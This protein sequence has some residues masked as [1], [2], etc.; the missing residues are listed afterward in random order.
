[1]KS[2]ETS[3]I[4]TYYVKS[5]YSAIILFSMCIVFSGSPSFAQ[6]PVQKVGM[7]STAVTNLIEKT[8]GDR[9]NLPLK[10]A[11]T[12][13]L[14]NNLDIQIQ[15]VSVSISEKG[16]IEQDARFD[17]VLFGEAS[18]RR[19]EQQTS[20]SLS[21]SPISKLDEQFGRLGIRK[22]F[23]FGLEAETYFETS[24]Y[25]NNSSF[26]GLDP[27]YRSMLILS[28]RQPLLQ[29]F[30]HKINTTNIQIAEN[31]LEIM[32]KN[33]VFQVIQTLDLSEQTYYNLSKAMQTL[34]L[35]KESLQLAKNLLQDNQ[36]RFDAGLT[37]IGEVQEAETAVA[38]RMEKV[39]EAGQELKNASNALKN[40]LQIASDCPLY[41]L[42][43]LAQESV[44]AIEKYSGHD[45]SL[46]LA[47]QNRPDYLQKKIEMSNKNIVL[48]YTKNQLLPRLD[49]LGTFGLNGLSGE[50]KTISFAGERSRSPFGGDYADSLDHLAD[51]D[52][53]EWMFGLSLEIPIGN[54]ADRSRYDQARL[55]KKMAVMELKNIEDSIDLEIKVA[56]EN[57]K[58]SEERISV[59][60]RFVSLAAKTLEQEEERLKNGLSNTFRVLVFQTSLIDAKIKKVR[61]QT[62]YQKGLASLYRAMGTNIDR[63][64]M[65]V[66]FSS[67]ME[68]NQ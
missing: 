19:L 17:P 57:I 34:R 46:N 7:T 26:E 45:K 25:R 59:T 9:V 23:K 49:I 38:S 33:F 66:N 32:K 52:G 27:Q 35:R 3:R 68:L 10:L 60:D 51:S 24:R 15:K 8:R 42:T 48:K 43:V 55:D 47:L 56:L 65:Y 36:D 18:D 29:D 22:L 21:G 44:P 4:N 5:C 39:I 11:L 31:K 40:I 50:A 41:P 20:S 12:I 53:Y 64:N 54:R 67:P 62:D 30:G 37:H 13:A 1:M 63:R 28:L 2:L 58:S 16:I 6:A 61:A 14:E